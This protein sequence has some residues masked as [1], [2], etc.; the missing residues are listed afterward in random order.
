[1]PR[2]AA[3]VVTA[4]AALG[5]AACGDDGSSA[6][7]DAFCERL[8]RLTQNDPFAALGPAAT[9]AEMEAAFAALRQRAGELVD[10]APDDVRAVA[11]DYRDAVERLDALLA[12]AGY[13]PDV[14]VRAYRAAQT[15][16]VQAATRL[17]RYLEA[18][19]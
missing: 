16:Y 4:L 13:G 14:D 3:L 2:L 12:D 8:D 10:V 5:T 1:M 17:E 9:E 15:D 7:P 19:C 18:E 6:D 11:A